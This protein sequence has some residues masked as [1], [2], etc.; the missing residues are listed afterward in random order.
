M[1]VDIKRIEELTRELLIAIG[2]DPDREGLRDTP[3][4]VAAAWSEFVSYKPGKLDTTFEVQARDQMVVV[5]GMQVHSICE[6]HLA[7]FSCEVAIGYLAGGTVLGLSKLARVAHKH[8]HR[9][10]LQER[11]VEEI[12]DEIAA[13]TGRADVAV[14]ASGVHSCMTTRGIR[15]P[16]TMTSCV[17]RGLFRESEAARA[18]FFQLV[19][20][21]RG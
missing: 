8:A 18:E 6:H 16:A 5:S 17:T 11:M 14:V 12:A 2:E 7:P 3:R 9:L 13:L 4:R 20:L 1:A 10:Q 21:H 19:G 15:T